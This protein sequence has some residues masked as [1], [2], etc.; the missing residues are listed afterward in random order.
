MAAYLLAAETM[1]V[2]L[3]G[4]IQLTQPPRIAATVMLLP[5][6]PWMAWAEQGDGQ[7]LGRCCLPEGRIGV[8]CCEKQWM[9]NGS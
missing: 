8:S 4:N 6:G 9:Q 7:T 5:T 1:P 3:N 2:V